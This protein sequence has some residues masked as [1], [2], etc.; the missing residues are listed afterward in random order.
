MEE[1]IIENADS[2]KGEEVEVVADTTTEEVVEEPKF[3]D[4]ERKAFARA[5]VA[6]AKVKDLKAQLDS[7]GTSKKS[8]EILDYGQKAFLIANGIKGEKEL[9]FVKSELKKSNEEL[10]S[11]LENDYFKSKLENFRALG[12]TADATPTGKRSGGVATDSVEYWMAKAGANAENLDE[13]PADMRTKVVNA[14]KA[15]ADNTGKFY[16]S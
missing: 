3:T 13:V 11:L 6:E 7:M 9:D 10:D 15:K 2:P 8:S 16:N 14:L 12:K 4:A 5:K 1:E